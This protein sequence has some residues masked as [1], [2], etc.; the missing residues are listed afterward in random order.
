MNSPSFTPRLKR[1][2]RLVA[3]L[4]LGYFGVEFAVGLAIGSVSLFAD[5]IDFL[6]DTAVNLLVLMALGWSVGAR[7][8]MGKFLALLILVPGLATVWVAWAKF[9]SLSAPAPVQLTLA[10][11]GALLVNLVCALLLARHRAHGAALVRAA[12]LSARNDVFANIAIIGAG[13]LTFHWASGWPDLLVGLGILLLNLHAVREVWE[14]A[15]H[16]QRNGRVP[17][18]AP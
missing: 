12:Y 16:E 10:G 13:A 2:I 18:P 7:A 14:A 9:A 6:E 4:N 8:R 17:P 15:E 5:S 3:L 1:T 11:G